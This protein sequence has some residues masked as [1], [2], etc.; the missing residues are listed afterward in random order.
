MSIMYVDYVRD[1][2][3]PTCAGGVPSPALLARVP[4]SPGAERLTGVIAATSEWIDHAAVEQLRAD[5]AAS[6]AA[7]T[8][9]EPPPPEPD[10]QSCVRPKGESP[11]A[12][13]GAIDGTL[14]LDL[15]P[16]GVA[17][18]RDVP[19]WS[20]LHIVGPVRHLIECPDGDG[21]LTI[22]ITEPGDYRI[23]LRAARHLPQEW[24]IHAR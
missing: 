1:S 13:T 10:W 18:V 24:L 11:A 4:V 14:T 7:A 2:G 6:I 3:E 21:L 23:T 20:V 12:L 8:P 22:G 19:A 17:E 9:D 15:L 5:H 16:S